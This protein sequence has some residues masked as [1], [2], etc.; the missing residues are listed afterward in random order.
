MLDPVVCWQAIYARDHRFDGRFFAGAKTTGLYCRNICPVPFARPKHVVLF[1]CAAAA[2]AAGFRP[3]KRCRPQ[4]APGTPAWLGTSAVVSRAFRLIL[5]G[6]LNE[7]SVEQLAAKMGLG[8]RQLRRLFVQHLGASPLQIA[9]TQRIHLALNLIEGSQF[10]MG[11]VAFC[12]GFNSIREFNHA[13]HLSIG[14][15]PSRLRESSRTVPLQLRES[16]LELRLSYRAPF[17]WE[18]LLASLKRDAIPGVELVT[19]TSYQRTIEIGGA[20]GFFAARPDSASCQ[21]IINLELNSYEGLAQTVERI[22]R[23][24]DLGADPV[25]IASHLSQDP[26]LRRSVSVH[27]GLRVPG[28]WDYF[29]T[30]VLAVLGQNLTTTGRRRIIARLVKTLGTPIDTGIRGLDYL[31]PRPQQLALAQLSKMGIGTAA[32]AALGKLS[33]T[34]IQKQISFA[35]SRTLEAVVSEL[36]A[37]AQMDESTANYVAMRAFGEPDAFPFRERAIRQRLA[38]AQSPLSAAETIA[39]AEQWRPWRAYAATHLATAL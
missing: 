15:S 19:D 34:T 1:P 38:S 10:P 31:F 33:A 3:C 16:S 20:R 39:A 37:A 23:I 12:S 24:F 18:T 8:S 5:E 30:T 2:E 36:S 22:R 17:D 4:A 11:E 9:T 14:Q 28:A 27:P 6:A 7:G 29:E 21:M 35:A 25:R 32:A 13:I 26:R